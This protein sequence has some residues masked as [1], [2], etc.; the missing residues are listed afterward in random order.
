MAMPVMETYGPMILESSRNFAEAAR[1]SSKV[2]VNTHPKIQSITIL[3]VEEMVMVPPPKRKPR[4]NLP[5][6]KD[7]EIPE[8]VIIR[9]DFMKDLER[10]GQSDSF[11]SPKNV[12]GMLAG[13][14]M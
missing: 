8:D 4:G 6:I 3:E 11:T 12:T 13:F 7:L 10:L 2:R 9:E 1:L 5:K 14:F